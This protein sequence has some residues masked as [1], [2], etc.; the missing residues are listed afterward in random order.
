M[1]D[2]LCPVLVMRRRR[3]EEHP[4]L[5]PEPPCPDCIAVRDQTQGAG[6]WC[7]AHDRPWVPP[8]RYAYADGALH[9]FHSDGL[10]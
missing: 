6:R 1:R 7:S 10:G 5:Q 3:Y 2:A 4:E 8:H 9:P